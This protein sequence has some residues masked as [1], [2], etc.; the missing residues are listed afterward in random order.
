[1]KM[2][3]KI[4]I[5]KSG[6]FAKLFPKPV[7]RRI[8]EIASEYS[9]LKSL[10]FTTESASKRFY[11]GEGERYEGIFADGKSAGF[12]T[13]SANTIGASG[14]SHAIN[15]QFQMPEGVYLVRVSYYTRYFMDVI[16]I[17]PVAIG[18]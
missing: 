1:M 12:E 13:V 17:G 4:R 2:S 5:S 7:A 15:S 6:K 3:E 8:R 9:N 14:L 16:F 11:V 10:S 18:A